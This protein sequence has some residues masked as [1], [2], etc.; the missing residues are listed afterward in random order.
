VA[1]NLPLPPQRPS[2]GPATDGR[3][4]HRLGAGVKAA[5]S[6]TGGHLAETRDGTLVSCVMPTR[7]RPS[8]LRNAIRLFEAQDYPDR[9]LIVVGE[10]QDAPA[11]RLTGANPRIRHIRAPMG[12]SI[13]SKRNRGCAAAAGR[14][15]AQWDDDDWY[16]PRRLSTQLEPIVSG[17]ADITALMNAP[18]FDLPAWRFWG[19]TPEL[20][21]TLFVGDVHGG[22][23]VYRH[24]VWEHLA[25]YPNAMLA[26]DA[27]LL[28][29]AVRRGARLVRID[30]DD[31]FV[32]VR[33][34]GNTWRFRCGEFGGAGRWTPAA[35][36]RFA[37]QDRAFYRRLRP[38]R[39]DR[40]PRA[41]RPPRRRRPLVS[42][43]MPTKDRGPLVARA[44][45]CFERQDYPDRELIVLDDG[46]DPVRGQ[47]PDDPSI[48]YVRLER[49]M[50][51]G[52][53]RNRGC[54]LAR[55]GVIAHWDDDDWYATDRISRQVEEL[56][57]QEAD[58]CGPA[59]VLFFAPARRRAWLY[60]GRRPGA[61][62]WIAGSGLCYLT[63]AWRRDPFPEIQIG[64]DSGFVRR[65][66]RRQ[67]AVLGGRHVLVAM[68]HTANSAPKPTATPGWQ[69]R[70]VAQI[71]ALL[72]PDY[73][74]YARDAGSQGALPI[75]PNPV[76]VAT[77]AP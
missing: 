32:Y 8:F 20:H 61:P 5:V 9:E 35:E 73:L 11:E 77:N 39:T 44:V 56:A 14:Y 25:R 68:V 30:G 22:T 75:I 67:I 34:Q 10:D 24:A 69:P 63:E 28:A 45:A 55:G 46:D 2:V 19:V 52:E 17:R 38:S 3:P 36:P 41:A 37:E 72:G 74:T 6:S 29:L 65:R 76:S 47:L 66:D 49:R 53:K 27:G 59:R 58:L 50:V 12:E 54:E 48:R 64:E 42:C 57:R 43:V 70:P 33:H 60:D 26:E 18:F 40:S 31:L 16:G 7:N 21:R 1:C 71:Q 23:L 15:I 13:G 51:L 62:L 4:E